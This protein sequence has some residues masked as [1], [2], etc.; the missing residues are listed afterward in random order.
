MLDF[1]PQL[2]SAIVGLPPVPLAIA[3]A[4]FFGVVVRYFSLPPLAGFLL[5]GF[6]LNGLGVRSNEIIKQIADAGVML[7]LFTIGL[8][9]RLRTLTRPDVWGTASLHTIGTMVIFAA[10]MYGLSFYSRGLLGNLSATAA[11]LV[12]FGLTFSSTVF[13]I[14][15]LEERGETNAL[16]GRSAVGILVIQ[17][18]FAVA[19][20]TFSAAQAPSPWAPAVILLVLL[21]PLLSGLLDR[22]GYRELLPLFGLFIALVIGAGA[23]SLVGLKPDLGALVMGLLMASHTRSEE[24]ADSLFGF[25]EILLIG[26]FLD[27]GLSGKPTFEHLILAAVLVLLLP[28]QAGLFFLLLTRFRLRARSAFLASLSLSTYSEFGLIVCAV[29][30]EN[31]W[32]AEGWVM[33]LAMALSLSFLLLAPLNVR[34]HRFYERIRPFLK[35]FESSTR[36]A[37]DLPLEIGDAT[38]AIFGM[39]RVGTGAYEYLIRRHGKGVVIG[40]ESNLEKVAQHQHAGRNVIHG[41][42]TDSD[43]WHRVH[44][45]PHHLQAVLLAMPE[46]RSNM[47]AVQQIKRGDFHG[48]I[49]AL[50][51]F[52]DQA[53]MLKDAG[54]HAVFNMY[55]EA[56]SGFAASVDAAMTPPTERP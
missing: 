9:L 54:V 45:A 16:H 10:A 37:E 53:R 23:F 17:D 14:K 48:F 29:S 21:R 24:L 2:S 27:I 1:L 36:H 50:A 26:F 39:G 31:G 8:K 40:I 42:A 52:A 38:V 33:V 4:F 25:K 56:G 43:F 41:D 3:L 46:Y 18:L 7:L 49:G 6:A 5:A 22:V 30:V 32:I 13:G 20:L 51:K 12:A 55:A 28:V 44:A 11:V 15:V 34:P 47:Y 19:F 35:R